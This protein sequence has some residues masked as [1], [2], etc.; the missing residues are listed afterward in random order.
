MRRASRLALLVD[1][2]QL[3]R[4]IYLLITPG[5]KFMKPII[6]LCFW[7]GGGGGVSGCSGEQRLMWWCFSSSFATPPSVSPHLR[8]ST[9]IHF[10]SSTMRTFT[11]AFAHKSQAGNLGA[12][13]HVMQLV[14]WE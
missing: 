7:L 11:F 13:V 14:L 10:S 9:Y 2:E 12:V 3:K 6:H 4:R 5:Y 8:L 1:D